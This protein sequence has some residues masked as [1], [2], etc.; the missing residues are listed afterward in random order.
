MPKTKQYED[1]PKLPEK[2]EKQKERAQKILDELYKHYP[3]P[4][5]ALDHRNPFELLCATILSAQCTDVRVNKTTPDL[6]EAYP[7]PELMA[8]A[9]DEEL[10]ELVRS[11]GFY[12]NKSKALK[13][14]SQTIV[15]KHDGQVPQNMDALLELYGVARKTAN[16]VLGNAFNIN[17][18]VVVDT[19]VRRFSN[20]YGLTEHEKNTDKIERDL[21]ALFP[22]DTWTDLSHLMIHHGRNACKARISEPPDHPLCEQY[23]IHCEC[24]EMRQAAE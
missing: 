17:V 13:R 21:M 1:L 23:G 8:E 2:T 14:S 4:H 6:F 19:H 11:T 18:G 3:N 20:R 12:R 16:V 22:R 9:P 24:Q 15:E 10:H 7:T 5:C